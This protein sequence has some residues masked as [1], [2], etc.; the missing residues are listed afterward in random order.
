MSLPMQVQSQLYH[1][2]T[3][4][5]GLV[6]AHIFSVVMVSR[7]FG[8]SRNTFYKYRHQAEHGNLASFDCTPRVH[9]SA[10]PQHIIDAVLRAK[11][12]YPSFGK[13]RLANVSTTKALSSP[14]IP[15]S[16]F[17]A[18]MPSLYH[19]AHVHHAIGVPLKRWRLTSFGRWISVISTPTS[20]TVLI[21]I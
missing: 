11:A 3:Q 7:L 12:Q 17:C 14:P 10:Q 1:F 16:V 20:L 2:K 5:L 13:Q 9:G 8:I 21:A 19:R 15:C 4:I 18:R 6:A